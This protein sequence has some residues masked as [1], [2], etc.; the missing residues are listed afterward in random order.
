MQDFLEKKKKRINDFG[1][2]VTEIPSNRKI[3]EN[4]EGVG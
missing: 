4:D 2:S 3:S 1:N